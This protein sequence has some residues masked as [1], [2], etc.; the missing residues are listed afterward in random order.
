MSFTSYKPAKFS[1]MQDI[2]QLT[3]SKLGLETQ[4]FNF[5]HIRLRGILE[6]SGQTSELFQLS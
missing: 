1:I 5:M 4:I 2:V 6:D 3:P